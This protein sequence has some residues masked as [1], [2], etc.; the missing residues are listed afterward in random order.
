M[1]ATS[2]KSK[3]SPSLWRR[4]FGKRVRTP[5][6]IQ[7]EAVECGAAS[8]GIIL[9]YYG[10]LVPLERL[11]LACGGSRDGSKESKVLKAA[12]QFGLEGK[13][14]KKEPADLRYMPLPM[15]VFWNF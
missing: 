14:F 4:R 2:S 9:G 7:M 10:L 1:P 6:V 3:G 12:S 11:R 15:I 5:T 13:G 8:L